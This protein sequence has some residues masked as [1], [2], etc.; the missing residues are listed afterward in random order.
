MSI[1][2]SRLGSSPLLFD[3]SNLQRPGRSIA[4]GAAAG[5]TYLEIWGKLKAPFVSGEVCYYDSLAYATISDFDASEMLARDILSSGKFTDALFLGIG[6]S[7]LGPISMLSALKHVAR[8][9]KSVL[10]VRF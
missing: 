5:S 2:A 1:T 4:A 7:S 6:G 10:K 8:K 9:K 3:W